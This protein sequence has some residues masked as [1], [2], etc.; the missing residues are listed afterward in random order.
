MTRYEPQGTDPTNGADPAPSFNDGSLDHIQFPPLWLGPVAHL[1]HEP[2]QQVY[3]TLPT[4][5]KVLCDNSAGTMWENSTAWNNPIASDNATALDETQPHSSTAIVDS[6]RPKIPSSRDTSPFLQSPSAQPQSFAKMTSVTGRP[7]PASKNTTN[8]TRKSTY[9]A[10]ERKQRN[11]EA[12]KRLRD[13]RNDYIKG[14]ESGIAVHEK[15]ITQARASSQLATYARNAEQGK[16]YQLQAL[17]IDNFGSE[18]EFTD[19]ER[20]WIESEARNGYYPS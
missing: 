8:N 7:K 16:Y 13:R 2:Y 15:L 1:P 5:D 12:Q 10:E 17:C 9:S 14:L 11:K 4:V 6:H 20:Q 19:E 18:H 3:D